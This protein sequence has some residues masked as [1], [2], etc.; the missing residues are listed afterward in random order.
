VVDTDDPA[1]GVKIH[2]LQKP[3]E[4]L[5]LGLSELLP[6]ADGNLSESVIKRIH[7]FIHTQS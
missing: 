6:E 2:D 1:T 7:T 4:F 5:F 3:G